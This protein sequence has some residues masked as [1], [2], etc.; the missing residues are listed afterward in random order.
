MHWQ[1]MDSA[2]KA[3]ETVI[4]LGSNKTGRICPGYWNENTELW[5]SIWLNGHEESVFDEYDQPTHWMYTPNL[6]ETKPWP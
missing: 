3:D 4:L 1:T 6:P 5:E 2:P